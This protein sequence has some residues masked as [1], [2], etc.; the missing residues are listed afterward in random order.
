MALE[1]S[2]REAEQAT[3]GETRDVGKNIR[4]LTAHADE[5][6]YRDAPAQR[7]RRVTR[8]LNE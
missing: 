4:L 6:E 1:G 2:E 5:G 8:R 3:D 7:F